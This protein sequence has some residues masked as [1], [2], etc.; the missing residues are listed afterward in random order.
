MNINLYEHIQPVS[1]KLESIYYILYV[2][3]GKNNNGNNYF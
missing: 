1:D 3:L 2:W